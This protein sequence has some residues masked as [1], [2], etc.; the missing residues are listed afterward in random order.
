MQIREY[1]LNDKEALLNL[2]DLNCPAYFSPEERSD[3]EKYLKHEREDYFIIELDG[4]VVAGGGIN[5]QKEKNKGV[6]SW[7]M[8]HPDYQKRGIGSKL[9]AFRINHLEKIRQVNEIGV[10]T[11]QFTHAFYA[12]CGFELQEIA[13]DYWAPGYDLYDMKY[14]GK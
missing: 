6:L 3:L 7:D 10:R 13:A 9:A 4:K 11:S 12:K 2:F 5:I 1:H 14:T 8:I